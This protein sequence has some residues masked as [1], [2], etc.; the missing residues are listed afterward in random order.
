MQICRQRHIILLVTEEELLLLLQPSTG[1]I[2][3]MVSKPDFDPN[4]IAANWEQLVNDETN[5]SLLNRATMGQY[6]PGSTFKIVTALTYLRTA[7]NVLTDFPMTAREAS[8]KKDHTIQCYGGTVHGTGRFLYGI[9]QILQ[10]CI[11]GD[12]N[13]AWRCMHSVK[14]S[15]DLLV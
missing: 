12:G 4:T 6:P 9:C 2:L 7:W 3:A 15:E 5:S 11:C 8:Q 14:T 13:T 10:L 1:K